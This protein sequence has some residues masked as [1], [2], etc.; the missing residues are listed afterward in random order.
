MRAAHA[1]VAIDGLAT[2]IGKKLPTD[3]L[4]VVTRVDALSSTKRTSDGADL[5]RRCAEGGW[6]AADGLGGAAAAV[7]TE[8][9]RRH[10]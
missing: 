10:S 8:S 3:I 1:F 2:R 9:A 6:V 7:S 4:G 5:M